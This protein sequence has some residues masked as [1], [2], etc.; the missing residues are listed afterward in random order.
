MFR[1]LSKTRWA[2]RTEESVQ[3]IWR[4]LE[5]IL[6]AFMCLEGS[7]DQET[8]TKASGLLNAT[9][10]I[11]FICGLMLLKNIMLKAKMLSDYL[12]SE[13]INVAGALIALSSTNETLKRVRADDNEINNEIEAAIIVAS[14]L[15]T[16]PDADFLRLHPVRRPSHRLDDNPATAMPV[17]C[18]ITS[19]NR[20]EFFKFLDFLISTLREKYQ[21]L[22]SVFQPFLKV[23]DP[24]GPG[25][26]EDVKMLAASLPSVFPSDVSATLYNEFKVFFQHIDELRKC[27]DFDD[28]GRQ[29]S[30]ISKAADIALELARQHG[31]FKYVSRV[32]QLFLTAAPSVCKNERTFSALKRVK[33]YL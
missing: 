8:K 30:E 27:G 13:N 5:A 3:A 23:M 19:F 22:A 10:N 9:C 7:K 4:S 15:G 18:D 20:C 2:A 24:K 21:S 12:Q 14:N 33:N 6:D 28:I 25:N 29:H 26:M 32:Y 31:L 16:D 17:F 11:D 1:N